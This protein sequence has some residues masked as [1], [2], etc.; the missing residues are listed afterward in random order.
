MGFDWPD[1]HGVLD[2]IEEELGELRE[3]VD[4]NAQH[5]IAD[6]MGDLLFALVNLSRH[7]GRESGLRPARYQPEV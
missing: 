5:E 7:L 3:A 6:E 2:K 1:L 4:R